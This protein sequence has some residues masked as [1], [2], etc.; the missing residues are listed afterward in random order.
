MVDGRFY[1]LASQRIRPQIGSQIERHLRHLLLCYAFF[2][3]QSSADCIT[4]M[5][6][7]NLRQAQVAN[8]PQADTGQLSCVTAHNSYP[9]NVR[10]P[11]IAYCG[12]GFIV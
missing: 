11:E 4:N 7:F 6:G 2:V 8:D 1:G 10:L 9:M 3:A 5:A 12:R